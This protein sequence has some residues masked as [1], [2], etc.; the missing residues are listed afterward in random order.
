HLPILGPRSGQDAPCTDDSTTWGIGIMS[1]YCPV[2]FLRGGATYSIEWGFRRFGGVHDL[3]QA[4]WFCDAFGFHRPGG[5]HEHRQDAVC[6]G[7]GVCAV[8]ELRT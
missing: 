2:S 3:K 1:H 7:Y 4:R 8:E 6:A 5:W